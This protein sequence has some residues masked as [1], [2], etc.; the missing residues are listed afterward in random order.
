MAGLEIKTFKGRFE[1]KNISVEFVENPRRIRMTAGDDSIW[2]SR[3]R[4]AS[5]YLL[6]MFNG[7]T[8][9]RRLQSNPLK[10][11]KLLPGLKTLGLSWGRPT[12]YRRSNSRLRNLFAMVFDEESEARDDRYLPI[13]DVSD[14]MFLRPHVPSSFMF[15]AAS[16]S[17]RPH[18]PSGLMFPRPHIPSSLIISAA[19]SATD[20][21]PQNDQRP[22][23]Q[24]SLDGWL[25][26][27][28]AQHG[29]CPVKLMDKLK[30][31]V[32]QDM[33]VLI[34]EKLEK[35]HS[36]CMPIELVPL[37]CRELDLFQ[38]TDHVKTA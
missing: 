35:K 28:G 3:E 37:L 15:P 33:H 5:S 38:V 23:G 4:R 1:N 9:T 22:G 18:V 31:N 36:R 2:I 34:K 6:K 12:D 8:S 25:E 19:K 14:L 30:G 26:R 7:P 29:N 32:H 27:V 13:K 11:K 10:G 21:V 17:Q 20:T 24:S 16:C